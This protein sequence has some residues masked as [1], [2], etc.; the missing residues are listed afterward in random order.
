MAVRLTYHGS[1]NASSIL[2]EG[3]RPG[4]MLSVAPG[5][6][7]STPNV[8]FA[9]G[10]GNPVKM[11]TSTNAFSLPSVNLSS[12]QIGRE[13]I[14]SP[15]NATRGMQLAQMAERLKNVSP[16]AARLLEGKTI[17]GI[18]G[19][20]IGRSILGR[21]LGTILGGTV[22]GTGGILASP[23]IAMANQ[24]YGP[25]VQKAQD[26][27]GMYGEAMPEDMYEEYSSYL[28]KQGIPQALSDTVLAEPPT[29]IMNIE[30]PKGFDYNFDEN[31]L[32]E[33]EDAQY[34][35]DNKRSFNMDGMLQNLGGYAKDAAGR[36]IGLEALGGAGTMIGGPVVGGIAA[37]AGLVGGGNLFNSPYIGAGAYTMDQYGNM[38]TA[39]QLNKMNARG[40]YYSEPARDSRRRDQSIRRM[41]ERKAQGLGYGINRLEQ[42]KQQAAQEEAAR[43]SALDAY[44]GGS[45][46]G[47]DSGRFDGASSRSEYDSNPT[48]YS[49][50]F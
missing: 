9:S 11:A 41:E 13:V 7:F 32:K 10:Y 20:S 49:G 8:N 22:A 44:F 2:Q 19:S 5:Q 24:L 42:L 21:T 33:E 30:T 27:A 25:N 37:L 35:L 1:P 39:D 6:V 18:G 12:G 23:Y 47:A 36:Y 15:Q 46:A 43:Q 26:F 50:P 4:R 14:Q 38:Y 17:R 34:N 16:T 40:G 29:G 48:G 45:D 28:G 31:V 3:F